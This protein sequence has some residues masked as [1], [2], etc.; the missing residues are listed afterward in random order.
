VSNVFTLLNPA[1][2]CLAIFIGGGD[3]SPPAPV[4]E[5]PQAPIIS[6]PV[7]EPPDDVLELIHTYFDPSEW[8]TA[9]CVMW[10]ESRFNTNVA[11]DNGASIG[12]Y[13]I[14]WDNI[15]LKNTIKGLE[16]YAGT[17]KAAAIEILHNPR[18]NVRI[19]SEIQAHNGWLEPW[20]AQKKRCKLN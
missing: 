9:I 17:T 8:D 12:L 2:I 14:K 11:G 6:A 13:Q 15:A 3:C 5:K 7:E 20:E 16:Y 19:A 10:H 1:F 4:H 18:E